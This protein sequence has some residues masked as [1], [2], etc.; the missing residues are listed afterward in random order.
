MF[1]FVKTP[2]L[3]KKLYKECVWDL[4]TESQAIHLTFDDGPHPQA[5][6]FVLNELAKYQ[7]KATFFCIGKNVRENPRLYQRILDEHH[8][9]GN[10]TF[11]HLNGW[12][13]RDKVY[14][15]NVQEASQYIDS[16]LFRPPY[17]RITRFQLA[18]L[19]SQALKYQV[20]MWDVLSA[21][22]DPGI[23]AQKCIQNVLKNIRG[24]S[25]VIFHD[26]EK[27]FGKLQIVL[28]EVL[29]Q[30]KEKGYRLEAIRKDYEQ[31][32]SVTGPED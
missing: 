14:L 24:G 3:L 21:D 5:T 20:I 12:K 9:V 23:T 4:R 7:A 8:R 11:N 2:W 18:A 32:L 25:I 6:T 16:N 19:R 31:K 30:V 26:S 1:Y 22:F 28:P 29:R 17:G 27:A 15:Q 13:T 10:H